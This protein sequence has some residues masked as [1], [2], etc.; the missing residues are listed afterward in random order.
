MEHLTPVKT[1]IPEEVLERLDELAAAADESRAEFLRAAIENEVRRREVDKLREEI[2]ILE[3]NE[4]ILKKGQSV[5]LD[6]P[7]G[8][9]AA[10]YCQLCL[11]ELAPQPRPFDGPAFC[12]DCLALARGGDFSTIEDN[13]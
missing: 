4:K 9:E 3:I 7:G 2:A 6:D 5:T 12:S 10:R 13:P 1:D 11:T 8:P